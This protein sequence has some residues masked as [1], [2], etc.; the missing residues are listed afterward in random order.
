MYMN[1]P[2]Q[3]LDPELSD[4]IISTIREPM[5]VL[6]GELR[7]I[8]ASRAFYDRFQTDY[9]DAHNK[10]FYEL[11]NGEWNIPELRTLLEEVLP[12][13]KT[14]EAFELEHTFERL[15]KRCMR[16][17][18]REIKYDNEQRKILISIEDITERAKLMHQK[19][20]LLKEMRHR[21][22]NSLQ[23]IASIILLKAHSVE[24]EESRLHLT[25]AHDRILSIATVQRNLDPTGDDSEVPVVEYLT[26]LCKSLSK[27]MIGGRKPITLTVSGTAGT[28]LPDE[29]ISL[30]LITTELVI[31]ALKHAFPSGEGD[32]KVTYQAVEKNWKLGIS[33]NGIGL[34][35]TTKVNGDG[36]GTNIVDSLSS[37]LGAGI[38][39]KSSPQGTDVWVTYPI[40]NRSG[41]I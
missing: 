2:Q 27:S 22:A 28:V 9:T 8:V 5:I 36:L 34:K 1:L 38:E 19:D 17:N 20:T 15:G 25:D 7:V 10:L 32:V 29:A 11:G 12:E 30:G 23:L 14:V 31:N 18:A 6:N 40:G 24:S 13:K 41:V 37:Q 33:D 35:A 21:I 39:R 26:T 3:G 16:I 4:A